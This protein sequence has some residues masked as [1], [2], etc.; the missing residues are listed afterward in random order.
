MIT[1]QLDQVRDYKDL[2]LNFIV[3]PVRKDIN[4]NTGALAVINAVKNLVLTN[5]YEKPFHPEI[6]SNVR[7]LLFEPIDMITASAIEREITQTIQ[8][9]EPRVSIIKIET[10]PNYDE[11]GYQVILTFQINNIT[12]PVTIT[13][14]LE[15]LR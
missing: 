7:K 1:V 6:G 8:N 3:H 10:K 15:R 11:D 14:Q 5:H 4:K 12:S 9:F 13:F 2:D